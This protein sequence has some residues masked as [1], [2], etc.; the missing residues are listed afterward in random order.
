[1]STSRIEDHVLLS[2]MRTAALAD[3][4]GRVTWLCPERFDKP[5]V[6]AQLLGTKENGHWSLAP[7]NGGRQA[8]PGV[9][10]YVDDTLIQQIVW[11]T[12]TGTVRLTQFMPPAFRDH[13]HLM[14]VVE[15]IDG[16][17]EMTMELTP[18]FGYGLHH[19]RTRPATSAGQHLASHGPDTLILDTAV[20]IRHE[21]GS[22]T[23][24]FTLHAGQ[25]ATFCLHQEPSTSE[26]FAPVTDAD[27][28]AARLRTE[29]FWRSWLALS[30]YA[31]PHDDAVRRSLLTL[32]ALT[33]APTGTVIAAPTTSLP[34]Q[35]GGERNWDYRY[36]WLR[37]GALTMTALLQ[38]GFTDEAR[39][40]IGWLSATLGADPENPQIM[41]GIGGEKDLPEQTLDWLG[42]YENSRPVRVGNKAADQLQLD[43]Y[44]EILDF[45]YLAAQHHVAPTKVI[46][47]LATAMVCAVDKRWQDPDEGIWEVRGPRRH[48]VHS[49]ILAW[50]AVDRYV[51]LIDSGYVTAPAAPWRKLR[52]QIHREVCA[53]GFDPVRN[54]FT[55]SYGSQEL[56]AA[57][58]PMAHLGFL[59][60]DD[61]RVVGTVDAVRRELA[62][63]D[64]LVHR[65]PTTAKVSD[66]DGLSGTEGAFLLCSFWLVQALQLTGS[67]TEAE[68]ML[69]RL[70]DLRSP[71]GLLAEEWNETMGRQLGN[72]PQAFSHLGILSCAHEMVP[73]RHA[74]GMPA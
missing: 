45:L 2:D 49:K 29:T 25:Q 15:V 1:M 68:A 6:L 65:Y 56:D 41:Y 17:V 67:T 44:G 39:A 51:Q 38:Y 20:P 61:A 60:P 3:V 26:A 71:H 4:S 62:T 31:G 55:Q 69:K 10:T 53:K 24:R 48:F 34:E 18:R 36:T 27:V 63:P 59:P 22:L 57:L 21:K 7:A 40:F 58:L 13:P 30:T 73:A 54:T 42:G 50:V 64:G 23:S 16:H 33:H 37:D 5:A 43:V 52:E 66:V 72:Y 19:P 12:T 47:R 46:S 11:T 8:P 74:A 70:L 28:V 35:I 14:R 32:K 9:S